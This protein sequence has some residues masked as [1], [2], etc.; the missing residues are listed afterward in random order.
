MPA[1]EPQ[2][3][4]S[5]RGARCEAGMRNGGVYIWRLEVRPSR[6]DFAIRFTVNAGI[7]AEIER[8]IRL[9]A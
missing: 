4:L 2:L 6:T 3:S 7:S 5:L 1:G 8:P 9:R